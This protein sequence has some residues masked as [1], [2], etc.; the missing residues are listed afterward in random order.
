VRRLALLVAALVCASCVAVSR[1]PIRGEL[2]LALDPELAGTWRPLDNGKPARNGEVVEFLSHGDHYAVIPGDD[3]H[4]MEAT[5]ARL[6]GHRYL[7]LVE[8]G[9]EAPDLLFLARY[10]IRAGVLS[11]APLDEDAIRPFVESG[12]LRGVHAALSDSGEPLDSSSG[13]T[14]DVLITATSDELDAFLLTHDPLVL[15]PPDEDL[16]LIRESD[17]GAR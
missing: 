12:A 17:A 4:V 15:F 7:N 3:E 14:K 10:E 2:P 6:G 1:H 16:T 9:S 11:I 5:T 8:V 13:R